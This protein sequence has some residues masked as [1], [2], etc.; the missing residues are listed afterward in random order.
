M[1]APDRGSLAISSRD[2]CQSKDF[3]SALGKNCVYSA[4][5]NMI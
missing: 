1:P 4:Y 5:A 2:F 3:L